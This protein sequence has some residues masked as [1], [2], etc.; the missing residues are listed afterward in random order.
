[1]VMMLAGFLDWAV[2]LGT[3]AGVLARYPGT[4]AHI[5]FPVYAIFAIFGAALL[6][7]IL[8]ILGLYQ[9]G[10]LLSPFRRLTR[11]TFAWFV[12]FGIMAGGIFLFKYGEF[13]SR[14]WLVSWA[15]TGV[16]FFISARFLL[17]GFLRLRNRDGHFNKRAVLVGG[18][19]NAARV[20][21]V[22]ENSHEAGI[23]LIGVFD[24]RDDARVPGEVKG[25]F[26]LGRI[27]DLISFVRSTPID[28][29]IVTLPT[30]AEQRLLDILDRLWVLPVDIRLSAQG[31]RLRLRP[32]AYSY[33][34]NL[35]CLDV[36][37]KPLG[38]WGPYLKA[39]LDKSIAGIML[40]LL[41]PLL[42]LIALA[43]KLDSKGP[44][45]FKQ[46]RYGFNNEL[47]EVY[48]FRSMRA[49]KTDAN[50]SKLVTRGD[51]RVTR[52]GRFI[53]R[54]TMDELPQ[55]FNV[56]KGD[57]SLVGPRPHATQAKAGEALYE[58]VVDGYFARHRVKPGLTGWAQINGWRGETDTAEK[59]E[60]RVEHDLYYIENWSLTFDLYI[61]ARTPLALITTQNA[62]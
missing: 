46:K 19:E 36:Y 12:T 58:H 5:E 8:H 7:G 2:V 35:P 6:T 13:I 23:N 28:T 15:I 47:I 62:Y 14:I 39:V 11:L 49:D 21:S 17:G 61:L 40:V 32:R 10:N 33:I 38:E 60:R 16:F 51:S 55:L 26:K 59:I 25:L 37:D 29:L 3:A 27:E 57:L 1:M 31:Q 53:R 30:T 22:I 48:K 20:I 41:A 18:G 43:I 45:I 4:A 44:V 42:G 56:L 50:A 54:T 34:G 24:D 52:V 9:F